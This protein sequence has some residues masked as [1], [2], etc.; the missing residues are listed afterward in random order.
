MRTIAVAASAVVCV[1]L[2][3]AR[4]ASAAEEGYASH[5]AL[6]GDQLVFASEGDLWT[7][8]VPP[9]ATPGP[10]VAHRLTA[11]TGEE[12]WPQ[13]SPDGKWIAFSGQYDGN[14]DV[15]VMP[16][17]GGDPRRLTYH[18]GPDHAVAWSPD[19]RRLATGSSDK[20]V[21]IWDVATGQEVLSFMGHKKRVESIAWSP[22]GKR[23][24]SAGDDS[25][26]QVYAIDLDLLMSLARSRVTRNLTLEECR[27]Y[28]HL[29]EV[30]PLP[31]SDRHG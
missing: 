2:L 22:D 6:H 1:S 4:A 13:L 29:D 17:N 12:S 14:V 25:V 8:T 30:P 26:V 5:P 9:A 3:A 21:K 18:P 23:L 19:G 28:L 15:F 16:A 27:S 31:F 10:V 7:A 24:A 20:T 11:S